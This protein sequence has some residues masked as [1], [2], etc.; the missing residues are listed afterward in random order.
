MRAWELETLG[1]C[2]S[3]PTSVPNKEEKDAVGQ[4][5]GV[6]DH[7]RPCNNAISVSDSLEVEV[8]RLPN[9]E[10]TYAKLCPATLCIGEYPECHAYIDR[11]VA[12]PSNSRV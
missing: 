9:L 5:F 11:S 7:L 1:V 3:C 2:S 10:R 12:S 8:E 6:G 4:S